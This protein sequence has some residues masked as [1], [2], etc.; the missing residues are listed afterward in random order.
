MVLVSW[1]NMTFFIIIEKGFAKKV[2]LFT[3]PRGR[4]NYSG[5]TSCPWSLKYTGLACGPPGVWTGG[6]TEGTHVSRRGTKEV[7]PV[8]GV[9]EGV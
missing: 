9:S 6:V 3:T 1:E 8:C 4:T 5:S 7:R 2:I